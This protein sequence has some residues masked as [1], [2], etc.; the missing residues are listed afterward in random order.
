[1]T[2]LLAAGQRGARV[3]PLGG[4]RSG[5]VRL[6]RFLRNRRVTPREMFETAARATAQKV[7]DRHVLVIQDT[8][9]LRDNGRDTG[10]YLHPAIALDAHDGALLGLAHATFLRREGRQPVHCNKR[11]LAEKESRRW[12]EATERAGDLIGARAARVTVVADREGDIYEEFACRPQGVEVV[13]RCHHDRLLADGRRLFERAQGLSE[14]GRRTIALPASPGRKKRDITLAL[15]A[16]RVEIKRPKRNRAEAAALL[17]PSVG[18]YLVEAREVDAPA[19]SEPALWRILTTH[20][21]ETSAQA[22]EIVDIYRERWTI[23]QLFRVMKTR[24]FD[25]EAVQIEDTAPFENMAAAILIAAIHVQQML[26]DRDG[27][28]GRTL[29]DVFDPTD[30]PALEAIGRSLEGKT[31][32]QR[33]P[34]PPG[35]LAYATW[36]CA[37]LAGWYGYY[38]KPGPIVIAEGYK[39]LKA[40]LAGWRLARDV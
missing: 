29:A 23:E 33:N 3:R 31:A 7:K 24:G 13:I 18:L 36:V 4:G 39:Q 34:H 1:L 8:T 19:G 38:G 37:R 15:R 5:E 30:K 10:L 17:P 14:L 11:P 16:A 9:S 25:V 21:V 12:I 2:R 27:E 22:A 35:S 26:R 40:M 20:E 6:G 28:A 32:R